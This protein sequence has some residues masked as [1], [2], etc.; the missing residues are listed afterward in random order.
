MNA[1]DRFTCEEM[2]RRLDDYLDRELSEREMELARGHLE[3]CAVC[4]REH[5]FES[6]VLDEIRQRVRRIDVPTEMME[7]IVVALAAERTGGMPDGTG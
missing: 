1:P 2:F 4:A 3:T 5:A 6:V 7:R